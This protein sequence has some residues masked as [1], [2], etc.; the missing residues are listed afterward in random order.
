MTILCMNLFHFPQHNITSLLK[1]KHF[2]WNW[3]SWQVLRLVK[4]TS[5]PSQLIELPKNCLKYEGV[6]S[7]LLTSELFYWS[8]PSR[9]THTTSEDD[10]SGVFVIKLES[11][12]ING[13]RILFQELTGEFC[14]SSNNINHLKLPLV[15]TYFTFYAIISNIS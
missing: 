5:P 14:H 8:L 2:H 7:I 15:L 9:G 1:K 6:K 11:P 3:D 13:D 12:V 4:F 10:G